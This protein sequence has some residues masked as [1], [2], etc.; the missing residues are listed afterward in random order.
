MVD[1]N[2]IE[3]NKIKFGYL[4]TK[5]LRYPLKELSFEKKDSIR[6]VVLIVLDSWHYSTMDSVI[7]P[8]IHSL[9]RRSQLFRNHNSGSNGTRG[10]IFSMFYGIPALYWDDM[11][12]TGTSPVMITSFQKQGYD[13]AIYASSAL[14]SP[15]FDRTVFRSIPKLRIGSKGS[16]ACERD[17]DLTNSF[18]HYIDSTNKK[19]SNNPF[20]GFLFYDAPHAIEHPDTFKCKFLPEW[21][22]PKYLSLENSTDP[23][24]FFNLYKNA[25]SFD[26]MLIG[27]VLAKLETSGLMEN[28]VVIITGDHGQ[29]FNDN[30]KNYWGHNG[31]FSRAQI[32]VPLVL[33]IPGN[34]PHIY[35]HQTLHYDI[36]PT[37]MSLVLGCKDNFVDYS[38]GS[39]LFDQSDRGGFVVGSRENFG[40]V[41]R[42]QITTVF[43]GGN[44]GIT[45]KRLNEL[46]HSKFDQKLIFKTIMNIN[47]FYKLKGDQKKL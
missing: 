42:D 17:L 12:S 36:S 32:G 3:R 2:T 11:E 33:Y 6:N 43:P 34:K 13:M 15:P 8:N 21:P 45:D 16:T 22:T 7:T 35:N 27:K 47:R 23:T 18:I 29:E 28:T 10:G 30:K 25:V 38:C 19:R 4:A 46:E 24:P 31:N 5:D 40:I 41:S 44:Y 1:K 14:S 26:D 37:I 9:A 39:S 20:F